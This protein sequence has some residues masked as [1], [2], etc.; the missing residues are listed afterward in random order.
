ML[1]YTGRFPGTN[2]LVEFRSST[3]MV[4]EYGY[5]VSFTWPMI[6][7]W[8]AN[9][10]EIN[11]RGI[12]LLANQ[13]LSFDPGGRGRGRVLSEGAYGVENETPPLK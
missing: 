11:S 2:M 12:Q 9:E 4:S 7:D 1:L 3:C 5:P 8:I 6:V 10:L 13:Y